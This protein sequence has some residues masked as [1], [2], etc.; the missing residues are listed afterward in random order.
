MQATLASMF[1]M[2]LFIFNLYFVV[3]YPETDVTFTNSAKEMLIENVSRGWVLR[4]ETFKNGLRFLGLQMHTWP[5]SILLQQLNLSDGA[6]GRMELGGSLRVVID[7]ILE[8]LGASISRHS[9][10]Y[11]SEQLILFASLICVISLDSEL[12]NQAPVTNIR[13]TL[14]KLLDA[15]PLSTW[16]K[17]CWILCSHCMSITSNHENLVHLTSLWSIGERGLHMQRILSASVLHVMIE[18]PGALMASA[19]SGSEYTVL[20]AV[21][22]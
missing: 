20:G 21:T 8:V 22:V 1:M 10:V 7:A 17:C 5:Q 9:D 19:M 16:R 18:T 15:L 12:I 14:A 3:A 6:T 13:L 11:S 4:L 2:K